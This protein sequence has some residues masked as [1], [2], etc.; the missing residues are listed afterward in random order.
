M[1]THHISV[2]SITYQS[3]ASHFTSSSTTVGVI[4][5]RGRFPPDDKASWPSAVARFRLPASSCRRH[6]YMSVHTRHIYTCV[7]T[8]AF[9]CLPVARWHS[10][11]PTISVKSITY[12][13]RA[14]HISQEHH[15]SVKT[16]LWA[17]GIARP[18]PRRKAEGEVGEL[19]VEEEAAPWY[20][21]PRPQIVFNRRGHRHHITYIHIYIYN[22]Y[23]YIYTDR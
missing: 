22:I 11:P 12:Q 8:L 5:D 15:I 16:S 19:I 20:H 13:S 23:I 4:D 17:V 2:Q 1:M 9:A 14:S 6:Q 21:H 7:T 18:R 3:R 10:P